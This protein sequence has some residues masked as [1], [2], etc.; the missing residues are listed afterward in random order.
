MILLKL[1]KTI[2]TKIMQCFCLG[3]LAY[4]F[5]NKILQLK[6]IFSFQAFLTTMP[7]FSLKKLFK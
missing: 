3:L 7:F 6:L 2:L 4:Y 1:I 5:G